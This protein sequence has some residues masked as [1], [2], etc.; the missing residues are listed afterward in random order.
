MTPT[1]AG[2]SDLERRRT[3]RPQQA[4]EIIESATAE[5]RELTTDEDSQV[6]ELMKS[7]HVIEEELLRLRRHYKRNDTIA[8]RVPLTRHSTSVP[9]E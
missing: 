7:A 5:G 2:H 1:N 8:H 9:L 3:D 6:L 4:A